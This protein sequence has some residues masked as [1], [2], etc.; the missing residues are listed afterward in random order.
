MMMGVGSMGE[1]RRD[2]QSRSY[3]F[4]CT[5]NGN[6]VLKQKGFAVCNELSTLQIDWPVFPDFHLAFTVRRL[7]QF[8]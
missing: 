2:H 3:E 8:L 6:H 4:V 5:G 1:R 7:T